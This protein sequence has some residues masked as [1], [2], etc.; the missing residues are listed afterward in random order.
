MGRPKRS[1]NYWPA[2]A[3][4]RGFSLLEL[5]VVLV[6]LG[7]VFT[8]LN[9]ITKDSWRLWE[10]S[11]GV[12]L[13]QQ[14]LQ[15]AVDYI[16]DEVR[17]ADSVTRVYD[18]LG[19]VHLFVYKGSDMQDFCISGESLTLSRNN[20]AVISLLPNV[21]LGAGSDFSQ[22]AYGGSVSLVIYGTQNGAAMQVATSVKPRSYGFK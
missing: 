14:D 18:N 16:G 21:K 7:M 12:S 2:L 5:L 11:T 17:Q 9:A 13:L 15:F 19:A 3:D 6:I 8:V 20:G 22:S 1:G 10:S 4:Q